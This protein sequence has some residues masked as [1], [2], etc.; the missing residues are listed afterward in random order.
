MD[1]GDWLR[2]LGLGQYEASFRDNAVDDT[3]LPALTAEDLKD[4]GVNLVG[5]RRKLLDAIAALRV[6]ASADSAV[7]KAHAT[8]DKSHKIVAERR[9]VT[10]VFSDLVGST[11]LSAGM[12]PEDLREVISA[13]QKSVAQTVRR[14][15]GFVAKYLGD[16]VLAYFGYPQAHEDD[17]ERAVRAG[18]ELIRVIAELKTQASLRTRVGIATGLVIV[19]DLIRSDEVQ[20]RGIVG[21]TPN[22][23]ARLQDIAEPNSVVIADATRRLVGDLFELKELGP[24]ELKGIAGMVRA[25]AVLGSSS[26]ES[27]FEA[28]HAHRLSA[29]VGRDEEFE[30]LVRRW[31][32]ARSGEGQVVSLS[33]EAGI[34]KSRL[35]VALLDRLASERYTCVRYFCSPQHTESAFYPIIRQMERA[36]ELTH[37]DTPKGRLDK[38]DA[39]VVQT[40]TSIQDAALLAEMMSLGNDGRYPA[41]ELAPQQRRQKTLQALSLR[42]QVLTRSSPVLMIFEDTH[43]ADASSLEFLSRMITNCRNLPILLIVTFRP[44][45]A[46]P[47]MGQSHVTSLTL[48]RLGQREVAAIIERLV[49]DKQLTADV[50]A[51]II[52]RTD[53]IPLFVE[54]MTKAVLEAESE[55]GARRA[56][57]MIP[58]PS[59][60]VPTTLHA[61]LM[62]RLDRLGPAKEV[63]QIAA[64]I[65]REFSHALLAAVASGIH[66]DIEAALDRLIS[67]GLL[68]RNGMPPYATYVFNHALVQDAAYGTLLREARRNLHARIA[69][70]IESQF[71]DIAETQPELVAHHCAEAGLIEKAANLRGRAAQKALARSALLEAEGQ[72]KRALSLIASLPATPALRR[73]EITLQVALIAP[74]LHLKGYAAPETKAAVARARLLIERAEALGEPLED[75]LLLFSVLY[76]LWVANYVALDANACRDLSAEVLALAEKQ[77]TPAPLMI[78]HRLTA[79]SLLITGNLLEA[80]AHFDQALSFYDPVVHRS[81][82]TQFGQDISVNILS[83]RS[84]AL[85]SLGYPLAAL[86][87]TE[88]ALK[89][90]R[91]IGQAA[92]LMYAAAHAFWPYFWSGNYAVAR[93]LVEEA[94]A[95]ADEKAASFWTAMIMMSRGC[96][97]SA[98]CDTS[99]AIQMINSGITQW[100]S[101]GSSLFIPLCLPYLARAHADLGNF[102]QA[103]QSIREAISA[104]ETSQEKWCEAEI[105]QTAGE[106]T[107]MSPKP[108]AAKAEAHLQHALVI[109]RQQH[110]RSWELRAATSLARLWRDQGKQRQAHDVLAPIYGWFTEGFDTPDLK[111]AKDLLDALV[112]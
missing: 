38:L 41:F 104:V 59:T 50:T 110:A 91:D 78:G 53:G 112:W 95:L 106:L 107:L 86:A 31:S 109:A 49:G 90:A 55:G 33:G 30:L 44:E 67:A 71:T 97:L 36:A 52:E 56:V 77:G 11:A 2:S 32:K 5:H 17:P 89:N 99:N 105:H 61:S 47:W 51:E 72:L 22:L 35:T 85:W 54:E 103:W 62:A 100:R 26:V 69:E 25:W 13:Y 43:W 20:E 88:H 73:E 80:R 10:V 18:L 70:V 98:T 83:L 12:D 76:G 63:A 39:L 15:D 9:Q 64:A 84:R 16:G 93:T 23:A 92:T 28:M 57:A 101:M 108:D 46:S 8:I 68:F 24:V 7:L 27:R 6:H 74:L 87:D 111:R 40:S 45:F 102:E 94:A 81:L 14:F 82:A 42:I 4:L 48:S 96:L 1:L 66:V 29:F 79:T 34:G 75:P 37:D 21:E 19:G 60:A 58:S 3:I 65:G